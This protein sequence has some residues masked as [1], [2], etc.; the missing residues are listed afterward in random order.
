MPRTPLAVEIGASDGSTL[1]MVGV[2]GGAKKC[3]FTKDELGFDACVD[4]KA[5]NDLDAAL[6]AACPNG[7]DVYFDNVGNTRPA[8]GRQAGAF[9]FAPFHVS[10][11]CTPAESIAQYGKETVV[12]LDPPPAPADETL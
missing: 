1:R 12:L 8:E 10:S 9:G 3:A 4:Y 7:I 5:A 2:A 6:R 11:F